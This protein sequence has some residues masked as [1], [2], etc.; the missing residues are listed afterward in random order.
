[1]DYFRKNNLNII[2]FIEFDK[3]TV[4]QLFIENMNVDDEKYIINIVYEN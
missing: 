1:M 4:F 3:D 2:D